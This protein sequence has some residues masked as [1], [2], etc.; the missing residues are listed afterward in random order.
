MRQPSSKEVLQQRSAAF[1]VFRKQPPSSDKGEQTLAGEPDLPLV[2]KHP[3]RRATRQP[4]ARHTTRFGAAEGHRHALSTCASITTSR[5]GKGK[6]GPRALFPDRPPLCLG[7]S[8]LE[9]PHRE[10]KPV[11]REDLALSNSCFEKPHSKDVQLNK[12]NLS[13]I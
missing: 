7:G 13:S 2:G 9:C 6:T 4:G 8:R 12:E 5:V 11:A 1:S 10:T 3:I